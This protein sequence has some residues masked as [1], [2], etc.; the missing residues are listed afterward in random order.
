MVKGILLLA[1]GHPNYGSYA[2]Q[3]AKTIRKTSD[4]PI[5]ILY[6]DKG[7][8]HLN[9]SQL[10]VFHKVIEADRDH[11]TK[12]AKM[13]PVKAK[14]YLNKYTPYKKTIFLDSDIVWLDKPID[15]LFEIL[16][17]ESFS[18]ENRKYWE[19]SEDHKYSR[20]AWHWADLNEVLK[21]HG[22]GK[23]Y[24][25]Q[26]E[27]I[28]FDKSKTRKMFS[29]AQKI[30]ENPKLGL[31]I[32]FAGDVPDELA[33]AVSML[34]NSVEPHQTPFIPFYWENEE[35]TKT[36]I[37]SIRENYYAISFGGALMNEGQKRIYSALVS[38]VVQPHL[39]MKNKRD[40]LPTRK[41][42]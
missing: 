27:F 11:Y 37:A 40:Y 29:D 4:I 31:S 14:V 15:E 25:I 28:Y 23:L 22:P 35:K 12:G 6:A 21:E 8:S 16:K 42:I 20:K 7:I 30:F 3:L 2:Y 32:P 24:R 18:I 38:K 13:C 9:E 39:P 17:E 19:L 10:S 34:K 1:I 36:P 33:F 26:S 5:S 41:L